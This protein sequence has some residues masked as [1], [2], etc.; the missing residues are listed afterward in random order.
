MPTLTVN[1]TSIPFEPGATILEAARMASI[2]IPTLCWYPKLPIVGNCRICLVSV[3]GQGKLV[4][5]CATPAADGMVVQTESPAAVDN[6]RGV[7]GLLL[8][9]YPGEHLSNGGREHPRNEFERYVVQYDV[10]VRDYHELPLRTGDERPGDVMIQH[11][12]TTCILCT[13]CVRACEDIQEVGVLDVGMRG[14][15]AHIIVG[16]DG[17]PDHAGCTWCG[18]CV[19][20]CPTGAIFEFIPKQRFGSEAVRQP[21]KV[22]RSVCPYCGVGCQLDV[23]VRDDEIMRVTSP[24]IEETTP[25]QGSTCVKGRF[26]YDFPQH[27]DRL[28]VPLIRKGWMHDGEKWIW[29]G[30][31]PRYREGPWRT[32]EEMGERK[33][34]R[35]PVRSVGKP[36]RTGTGLPVLDDED[37]V[38]DR[39]ATPAGWYSAFREATWEEAMSLT[40]QE[41]A[42]I[43]DSHSPRA[44]AA[45]SSAKCSNEDNYAFMRMVRAALRTNSVDH[46]TRLCHSSSVAAMSR[47]LATSAASGSM[48][49]IEEACDVIFI[50]GA[51]TTET[52]PVFGALIKRAVAKGARLIVAD[53]RRTELADLADVHLQMMPGTDVALYNAMLNHIIAAGLVDRDFVAKWTHDFEKVAASVAAYTP[54]K[55]S[56][57][58]GIPADTIRRAAEMYARGPRTS[59]LWAMGLTQHNTGTD[60]VASLL[61]LMLA[62]G[63][64]G[65]WGAAMIPIRGQNNVQGASDVGAIPFAYTDYRP[66]TDPANRAEYA[67]AWGVP[68]ETL[69]LERGMMV[70]EIVQ[71][72]SPIRGMYIMGENPVISDPNIAHAEAWVRGLEFLAVQDLFLT[73]T[74][75]WA[76]VVLP[77]SSFAEKSGTY[78]N[79][80][81]HIQLTDAALDPPGQARRDLDILIELST[82]LGLATPWQGPADVMREIASVTPSWR[83]VSY[84]MLHQ[85]RSIQ[86]PVPTPDSDGTPFLFENGF[87]T[88]DARARFIPVEFLPPDEM[89]SDEFPY[90]LNTGRQMYHWHTGTMSRRS[91]GLDSR[92]PVP[93]VEMHP[94][95]AID[96]GVGEGET[97]RV[98]SRRGSILIGVRLSDR[99]APGQIFI[100]MH[101]RE[102]AA[103]LLTNPQLDPYARIA[104]FKIS[105]VRIEPETAPVPATVTA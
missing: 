85:R 14:E 37:D 25:N 32:I 68:E 34:P 29:D 70:T 41:L 46:C 38:R 81:R 28:M 79:T 23:H 86:Y 10:P 78:V 76:D 90:I 11:D 87:P 27:R 33:K 40:A 104:A 4:P 65:K 24:W 105:A 42:R 63:M 75:R 7:L 94:S 44:L 67:R 21:D 47:A 59:T 15:Y 30:E 20:V 71:D 69:S 61:N 93:I 17:D 91:E 43:R 49:E 51:N 102:A 82:R 13:R 96:L 26:G 19:R 52:H 54:E 97:V 8:E 60:I 98:T 64:I 35:P 62:C 73:E 77:A 83:G 1:G 36:P 66:V 101:F 39:V 58:T 95:D 50:S 84:E 53:V 56:R 2:E 5:A 16:G 12:M 31:W 74:A 9:R 6:R 103:N 48:R 80:D 89:P 92:E 18:E 99:Q 88:P 55:S 22:V 45:L 72:G 3:E 100:P 57:I